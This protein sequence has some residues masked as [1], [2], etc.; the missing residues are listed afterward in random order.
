MIRIN[1]LPPADRPSRWPVNRLLLVTGFLIM[2]IFSS[3]YSYSFFA[4]WNIEKQLQDT[5]NQHQLLQPTRVIMES[6]KK[7]QQV[8]DQKNAILAV[9]TKERQSW[10]DHCSYT[11]LIYQTSTND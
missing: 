3:M 7:K 6:T 11:N 5:R 4:V 1:L 8:I 9:L 10:Y 2:I